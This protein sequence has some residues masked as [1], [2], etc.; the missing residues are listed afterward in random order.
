MREPKIDR[1]ADFF[2]GWHKTTSY[3]QQKEIGRREKFNGSNI[4]KQI[5]VCLLV[6]ARFS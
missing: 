2:L 1:G 3:S 6:M 5:K 4:H